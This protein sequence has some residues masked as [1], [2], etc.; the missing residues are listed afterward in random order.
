ML[1]VTRYLG[2][3]DDRLAAVEDEV[4]DPRERLRRGIKA[5]AKYGI[6]HPAFLDCALPLLRQP[7]D[8]LRD[9]MSEA[10]WVRL[11]L[12]MAAPIGRLSRTL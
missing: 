8:E 2:E 9:Q 12:A 10:V 5:F 11:G 3:M 7:A 4:A 6:A 1:T